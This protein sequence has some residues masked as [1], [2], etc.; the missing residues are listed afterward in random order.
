M[1]L[2][3]YKRGCGLL[4][5]V[6]RLRLWQTSV[7]NQLI[8]TAQVQHNFSGNM[9]ILLLFFPHTV[10]NLSIFNSFRISSST[11]LPWW[12]KCLTGVHCSHMSPQHLLQWK[13]RSHRSAC[14]H[15]ATGHISGSGTQLS[16]LCRKNND[17]YGQNNNSISLGDCLHVYPKKENRDWLWALNIAYRY[18]IS[19]TLQNK[20][21][22]LPDLLAN[23]EEENLATQWKL[24]YSCK[25]STKGYTSDVGSLY[26]AN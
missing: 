24:M 15:V 11:Y 2:K 8:C 25:F 9:F 4:S 19:Q 5:V 12:G 13:N 26:T 3:M 14:S 20:I 1:G 21:I 18:I 7:K 22:S 16:I 6:M 10:S 23:V 17:N